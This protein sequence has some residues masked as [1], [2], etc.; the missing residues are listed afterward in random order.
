MQEHKRIEHD[1]LLEKLER[2]DPEKEYEDSCLPPG[3]LLPLYPLAR[4]GTSSG[5]ALPNMSVTAKTIKNMQI[6]LPV[7]YKIIYENKGDN[8][9]IPDLD[10]L[11]FVVVQDYA[12]M[13]NLIEFLQPFVLAF[14]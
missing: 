6:G 14:T 7:H 5:P 11:N 9:H 2:E 12:K 8:L 4:S 10:Q 3:L 13:L 1:H